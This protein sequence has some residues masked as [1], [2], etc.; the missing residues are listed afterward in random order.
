[1]CKARTPSC[2]PS[3]RARKATDEKFTR[4]GDMTDWHIKRAAAILH[5]GGIVAYPTEGVWGLGCDPNNGEAVMRLLA[6]KRRDWQKGL[7]VI[8][9]NFEQLAPYIA[10]PP[11]KVL[12]RLRATWPGP[13][14]WL[15]P[16]RE[17][18]APW[19]RGTHRTLAVRVTAHPPAAALCRRFGGALV[20]TS[21]NL[22]GRPAARSRLQ[23][24]RRFGNTVDYIV[25]GATG[26]LMRP[27]EIRDGLSGA[28]MRA[29]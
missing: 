2:R 9:A 1:M 4:L 10:T 28:V 12:K 27:T 20:S 7:I 18:T 29:G 6:I 13:V 3:S 17:S 19:L 23:V 11:P 26:G 5:Q 14:T 21:A 8:A 24:R 22:A 25:P 15:L 16:A